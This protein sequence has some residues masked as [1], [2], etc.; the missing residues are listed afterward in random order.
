M[1]LL[2]NVLIG[3][4]SA[5]LFTLLYVF[6]VLSPL[7]NS[8]YD[9][10]LRFRTNRPN[11]DLVV[12]LNV[13]DPAIAYNGIYPWPRS[14]PA[15]SLLRLKEHG[16]R[17]A[18]FDIEY[19]DRGP[20]G[21][22][23]LYLDQGLPADFDRSFY[24]IGSAVD[25]FFSSIQTG[26]INNND[27]EYYARS[28]YDYIGSEHNSLFAKAQNVARDN[29]LY[30]AQAL[31]LF[32]RSWV[33]LNLRDVPLTGEQ[34]ER[35]PFAEERFAYP[36]YPAHNAH[37]GHNVDVLPPLPIFAEAAVGAGFTNVEIDEDG[38]RRRIFLTQNIQD[39][40]YLQLS[41]APLIDYLGKPDI[42]LEKHK[43]T[44]RQAKMPDGRKK[45]IVIPLD[46]SGR[47][48]LDW[49]KENYFESFLHI[50]FAEFS[51]LEEIE[52]EM[53]KYSNLLASADLLFFAQFDSELSRMPFI[54]SDL[55]SLFED[56]HR[57][58]AHAMEYCSEDSFAAY[59]GYRADSRA[60]FTELLNLNVI[61]K[62]ENLLP[63]LYEEYPE[64][65]TAIQE[66]AGYIMQLIG[67]IAINAGRESEIRELIESSVRDR[68]CILGRSD[69]GTTDIGANPFWGKYIN[70]GTH[71]VVLDTI[72]SESF[73]TMLGRIWKILFVMLFVPL[74]FLVSARLSPTPR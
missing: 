36:V 1:K 58:R 17:V 35:R 11:I 15:D 42:I 37:R 27:I 33:T 63:L 2:R 62:M 69:T 70:V 3:L 59:V 72:L 56:I 16:A 74:F 44:I 29:D 22:D 46:S 23:T 7:E 48:M 6:D 34:A 49:P 45:D 12:F 50:S 53:E 20:Q 68:F 25:D 31:N 52:A 67:Y 57:T 30:L 54:L 65:A 8:L 51:Q 9:Y 43:M 32:G 13:D 71:A 60:L 5:S 10:F 38:I 47:M 26:R 18:V 24:G 41:F 21:V 4:V 73:I 61:T 40:W 55:E 66:E 64:A 28:L 19:I 39:H 14:I